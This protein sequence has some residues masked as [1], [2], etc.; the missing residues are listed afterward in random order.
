MRK[1]LTLVSVLMLILGIITLAAGAANIALLN[2]ADGGAVG[3]ALIA[4]TV[5][6]LIVGG[7]LDVIGGLLGLRAAKRAY[8]ATAAIVFGLLALIAG[9]VSVVLDHSVQ[10]I[11]GCVIPLV[12]FICAVSVKSSSR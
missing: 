6:V 1:G 11:C 10:N 8:K 4:L 2:A 9:I 7:A 3:Q 12:Y 5:I